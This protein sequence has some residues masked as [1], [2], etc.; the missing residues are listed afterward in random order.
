MSIMLKGFPFEFLRLKVPNSFFLSEFDATL[1]TF[2]R[3]SSKKY[4][5]YTGPRARRVGVV[6]ANGVGA[7]V[8]F[9]DLHHCKSAKNTPKKYGNKNSSY[10]SHARTYP[11][12]G[13]DIH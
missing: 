4:G 1:S 2:F 10:P 9:T 13:I 3:L 5:R 12:A 11:S 6:E 8:R 7:F